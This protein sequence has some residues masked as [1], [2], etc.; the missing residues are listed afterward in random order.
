MKVKIVNPLLIKKEK[1][2]R[3]ADRQVTRRR[4]EKE[5]KGEKERERERKRGTRAANQHKPPHFCNAY[6][7]VRQCVCVC[8]LYIHTHT[9]LT[10]VRTHLL[11][12]MYALM[13][14]IHMRTYTHTHMGRGGELV[15]TQFF[16]RIYWYI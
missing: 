12:N 11:I 8:V 1:K 6:M 16:F 10:H 5:R 13:H 15:S 3:S 7:C 9:L 2:I 4:K 14:Y